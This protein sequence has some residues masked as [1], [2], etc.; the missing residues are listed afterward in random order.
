VPAHRAPTQFIVSQFTHS[1]LKQCLQPFVP[2]HTSHAIL[3]QQ[4]C[5]LSVCCMSVYALDT[6]R[7]DFF[8]PPKASFHPWGVSG[9]TEDAWTK[10][11]G[12]VKRT[13]PE[14]SRAP[15]V[16]TE[17]HGTED[18]ST[19]GQLAKRPTHTL[20]SRPVF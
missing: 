3:S 4:R 17:G 2:L 11:R 19:Q 15:S 6:R 12:P 13:D 8:H 5:C 7:L 1:G 10:L 14:L 9:H 20:G 16:Y 18:S